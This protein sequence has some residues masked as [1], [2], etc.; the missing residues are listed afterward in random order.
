[1]GYKKRELKIFSIKNHEKIALT[2]AMTLLNEISVTT[3]MKD[4]RELVE[5][6]LKKKSSIYEKITQ[7]WWIN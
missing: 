7:F 1:M 4:A 5:E 6:T 2:P 3:T